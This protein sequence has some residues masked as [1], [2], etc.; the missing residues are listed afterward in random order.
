MMFLNSSYFSGQFDKDA[1]FAVKDM[2]ESENY[3]QWASKVIT[4]TQIGT[5]SLAVHGLLLNAEA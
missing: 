4:R 3:D 2:K 5:S 1:F